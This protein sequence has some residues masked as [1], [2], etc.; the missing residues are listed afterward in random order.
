MKKEFGCRHNFVTYENA[1]E[2]NASN[3]FSKIICHQFVVGTNRNRIDIFLIRADIRLLS[4]KYR[5]GV[6]KI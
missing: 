6:I 4:I 5:K 2:I 3:A 1:N